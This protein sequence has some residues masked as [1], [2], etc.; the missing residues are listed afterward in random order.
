MAGG[1][2][3][4]SQAK[5]RQIAGGARGWLEARWDPPLQPSEGAWCC[6]HLDCRLLASST[7]REYVSVV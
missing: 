1:G 5:E 3:A 2:A 7:V 6:P 4:Q